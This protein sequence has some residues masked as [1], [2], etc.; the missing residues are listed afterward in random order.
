MNYQ[1]LQVQCVYPI[2]LSL[3]LM[4][5][6][7]SALRISHHDVAI[8]EFFPLKFSLITLVPLSNS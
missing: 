4:R 5:H 3:S 2:I 1:V 8:G 6:N 7:D